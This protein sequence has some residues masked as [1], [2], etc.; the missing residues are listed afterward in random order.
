[1]KINH[2]S[3]E[4]RVGLPNA[5]PLQNGSRTCQNRYQMCGFVNATFPLYITFA[6]TCTSTVLAER[7]NI[8]SKCQA[9]HLEFKKVQAATAHAV[10]C[11]TSWTT[12]SICAVYLFYLRSRYETEQD[13][14]IQEKSQVFEQIRRAKSSKTRQ[15]R[16]GRF[17]VSKDIKFKSSALASE[18]FKSFCFSNLRGCLKLCS[19]VCHQTRRSATVASFNASS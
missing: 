17:I 6:G 11:E 5:P 19:F 16:T 18:I 8:L 4:S 10:S 14:S 1:M 7:Q 9:T 15:K 2:R 13:I 3:V 12:L